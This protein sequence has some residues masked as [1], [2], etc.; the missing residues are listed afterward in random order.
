MINC[1]NN[2]KISC[3]NKIHVILDIYSEKE[4]ERERERERENHDR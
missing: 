3:G 2:R 1:E 4:R